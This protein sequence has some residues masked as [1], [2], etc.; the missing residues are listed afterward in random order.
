MEKYHASPR[1]KVG[2]ITFDHNGDYTTEKAEEITQL[3]ALVP[4]WIT[5]VDVKTE[6]PAQVDEEQAEDKPAKT[7]AT[8]RKASATSSAK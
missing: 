3:D 7:P 5:R 6:E 2:L 4:K 1:Y 8:K